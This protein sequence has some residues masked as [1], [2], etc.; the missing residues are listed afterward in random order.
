M[1]STDRAPSRYGPGRPRATA[2]SHSTTRP[3]GARWFTV[4]A[5]AWLVCAAAMLGPAPA[6]A[7]PLHSG[8]TELVVP[9]TMGP[10][11]VQVQWARHGGSAALYLLDGMRARDDANGWAVYTNALRQFAQ[12]NITVVMPVGGES[13]FYTDWSAPSSTNGQKTTYKWET[14]LTE[15]LPA[16]LARFGVSPH[17]DAILGLSM[18]AA[19]ALSLAVH[20]R[21]QFTFAGALS[22]F[23][24]LQDPTTQAELRLAMHEVGNF[25]IDSMWPPH[26]PAWQ[27]NDPTTFAPQLRGLS[28]F[29]ACGSGIPDAT[30]L[31]DTATAADAVA[32]IGLE[33]LANQSTRAFQGRLT[34]VGVPAVWD[35]PRTG[36]HTWPDWQRE[37]ANAR[38][39]ILAA[40][41][42]Q[43]G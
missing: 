10:I 20:H 28:L 7:A 3:R 31:A 32:G 22:G 43:R 2:G 15:E 14:F 38:P 41:R 33:L 5:A 12:D 36:T 13:S 6:R 18:S 1:N 23:F 24:D 35:L 34:S 16:Y 19:P 8:Y 21:Q 17:H 4:A 9:S 26:S 27:R 25:D 30:D 40:T 39:Y 11:R 29:I 42:A 37:L